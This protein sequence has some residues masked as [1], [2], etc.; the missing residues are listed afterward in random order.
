[1]TGTDVTAKQHVF[2][3]RQVVRSGVRFV[4]RDN[5]DFGEI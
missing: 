5:K 2:Q 3:P 4:Q 1:V